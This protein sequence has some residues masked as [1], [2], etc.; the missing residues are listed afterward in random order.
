MQRR[1]VHR[2]DRGGFVMVVVLI[3]LAVMVASVG[4]A[5]KEASSGLREAGTMR[6]QESV[7]AA[8]EH[9][10]VQ[11]MDRLQ[12]V[13]PIV[14]ANPTNNWDIF[15]RRRPVGNGSNEFVGPFAYPPPPDPNPTMEVRVGLRPGQRTR[16]P[17]GEDVVSTY[18]FIVEVQLAARASALGGAAEERAAIGVRVPHVVSHSN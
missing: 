16:P 7:H 2:K 9:G 3:L 8:L 4:V 10:L 6:S 18:G 1:R 15:D 5:L 13:D 14:L 17:A 12:T 11:A